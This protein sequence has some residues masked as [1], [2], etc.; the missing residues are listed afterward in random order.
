MRDMA[1]RGLIAG[2][3]AL[4]VGL[5]LGGVASAQQD[6]P[7]SP[8][9]TSGVILGMVA[10]CVNAT[11]QPAGQVAVG[12]EGGSATLARTDSSGQFSLALPPGQYT[13]VATAAD[14]TA[15]RQYVPVEAG[16]ALDIGVLDIGIGFASCGPDAD[17]EAPA[18]PTFTPTPVP[19]V[20]TPTPTPDAT[21]TPTPMPPSEPAS[22]A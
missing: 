15:S 13:I 7:V 6:Q 12:V 16:A 10:R 18:L 9:Q 1:R 20:P 22:A 8:S 21:P 19:D 5:V 2:A 3:S 14:G 17:T 4:M 11:E